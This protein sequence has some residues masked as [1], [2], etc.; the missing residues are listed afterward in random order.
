MGKILLII[1]VVLFIIGFILLSILFNYLF[2][3]YNIR[4][5]YY[6]IVA[7]NKYVYYLIEIVLS[8]LLVA[9]GITAY[10]VNV[11]YLYIIFIICICLYL[12]LYEHH[13]I[14][15]WKKVKEIYIDNKYLEKK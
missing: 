9:L 2:G 13:T 7:R 8:V 6:S 12:S 11:L 3:K 5:R 10:I 1:L 15:D 4:E 14:G